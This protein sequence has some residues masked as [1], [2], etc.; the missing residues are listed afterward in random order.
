MQLETASEKRQRGSA[1]VTALIVVSVVSALAATMLQVSGMLTR[2][3]H[4]ETENARAFYIAE[5]GLSEAYQA[6]RVG[7]R[8]Q[9]GSAEDPALFGQGLLW[10]EAIA[11]GDGKVRLVSTGLCGAGRATLALVAEPTELPLGFFSEED[12]VVDEVLLVDGYDSE[13]GE[14]E[15]QVVA[16]EVELNGS[17]PYLHI[18]GDNQ[19]LFQDGT[20]YRYQ[21]VDGDTYTYD[22]SVTVEALAND[23]LYGP[24]EAF[25]IDSDDFRDD[26]WQDDFTDIEND[27]VLAYF[28]ANPGAGAETGNPVADAVTLHAGGDGQIGSNGSISFTSPS[29]EP[30]AVYG[31][32]VPGVGA[33]VTLG[34]EGLVTGATAS[35]TENVDLPAIEVPELDPMGA[36]VQDGP[37]P[38][39][40]GSMSA[41]YTS[42]HVAAD[43]ELILRGPCTL[44]VGTF[45]LDPGAD[46][47]FDTTAGDV[48]LYIESS[49]DL[50]EGSRV[51]TSGTR[52]DEIA[53]QVAEIA[54]PA[55]VTPVNLDAESEFYGTVYS[56]DT[57]VHVGADF[58]IFGSL[59]AKSLDLGPGVRLHFDN[60]GFEG[61]PLPRLLS[62]RIV[63]IPGFARRR[64]DPFQML[65]VVRGDLEVLAESHDLSGVYIAISYLDHGGVVRSYSG[66]E[67]DF[68]WS[69]VAEVLR[70]QRALDEEVGDPEDPD[71]PEDPSE[72]VRASLTD[73]LATLTGMA[74]RDAVIALSPLNDAEIFALIDADAMAYG[75]YE[76]VFE[77]ESPLSPIVLERLLENDEV[78]TTS[79]LGNLMILNSPLSPETLA[80]VDASPL[81]TD[82]QRSAIHDAQ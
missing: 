62:W 9:I 25:E 63:E 68:V 6:L 48:T 72:P 27:G 78:L 58:E 30:V 12:L 79:A 24:G 51:S 26:D 43:A 14:Y 22:R 53:I 56:P 52:T 33:T 21:S 67:E 45:T 11:E 73:A 77:Q 75:H 46:L 65:G 2:E 16:S 38:L 54:A 60:A 70:A 81:L 10:V 15:D 7:R 39:V 1:L 23:P 42:I 64:G 50:A 32:A 57:A 3:L 76:D 47:S 61:S 17:Y 36:V 28:V 20:F 19:I 74:L 82:A 71:N 69:D 35:R 29:G 31:D 5:A 13:E 41:S 49:M 66:L 8:G 18:D 4:T 59:A 40:I 80:L 37:V 44:A 55:G 34:D